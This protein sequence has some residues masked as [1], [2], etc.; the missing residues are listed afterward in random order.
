[1]YATWLVSGLKVEGKERVPKR[2]MCPSRQCR[3]MLRGSIPYATI[4]VF[5]FIRN[6]PIKVYD[7]VLF[8]MEMR[9][10]RALLC[11]YGNGVDAISNHIMYELL[12]QLMRHHRSKTNV[13]RS[14]TR[15]KIG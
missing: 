13:N 10:A 6:V 11:V 4:P 3:K 7:H 14:A 1:M 9:F 8:Y 15:R 12:T 2:G 5:S